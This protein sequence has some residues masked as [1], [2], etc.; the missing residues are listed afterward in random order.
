M[1]GGFQFS[2]VYA[3]NNT[4]EAAIVDPLTVSR[5]LL[6]CINIHV[7]LQCVVAVLVSVVSVEV[8]IS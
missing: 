8:R 2:G 6:S 3:H 7:T 1:F 4:D 5:V